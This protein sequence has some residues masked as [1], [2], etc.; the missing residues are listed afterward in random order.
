MQEAQGPE[1]ETQ[2]V[3]IMGFIVYLRAAER[4]SL[5]TTFHS[6]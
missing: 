3:E 2:A 6:Y 1:I 5:A 4:V